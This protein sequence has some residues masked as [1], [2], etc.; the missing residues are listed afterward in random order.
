MPHVRHTFGP[1]LLWHK[2]ILWKS[3]T[4]T[5]TTRVEAGF[6]L[7]RWRKHGRKRKLIIDGF[8]APQAELLRVSEFQTHLRKRLDEVN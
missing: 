7:Q 6:Q 5:R 1:H 3:E 2:K 4:H 8:S